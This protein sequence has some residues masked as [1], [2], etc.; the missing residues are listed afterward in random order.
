M[1]KSI[2]ETEKQLS[3]ETCIVA[4]VVVVVPD[5][6]CP[7]PAIVANQ[8]G[9]LL[10]LGQCVT[11]LLHWT[12]LLRQKSLTGKFVFVVVVVVFHKRF[13]CHMTSAL[14]LCSSLG[15]GGGGVEVVCLWNMI[16][17]WTTQKSDELWRPVC[18]VMRKVTVLFSWW[19]YN[20][21]MVVEKEWK[22]LE[23]IGHSKVCLVTCPVLDVVG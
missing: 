21:F 10:W 23:R 5:G 17:A 18:N 6:L 11:V 2:L 12:R 19:C 7:R 14:F 20:L 16:R 22:S 3:T 4:V 13:Q 1:L 8:P 15:G 9:R